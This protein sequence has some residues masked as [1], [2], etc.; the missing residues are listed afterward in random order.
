M[1]GRMQR[2]EFGS[3]RLNERDRLYQG[4]IQPAVPVNHVLL[5]R[6]GAEV[7]R[8]AAGLEGSYPDFGDD[9][10][11]DARVTV[12]ES[13]V[14]A[15]RTAAFSELEWRPGDRLELTAGVR[16]DRSSLTED[17]TWD[18]RLGAVFRLMDDVFL[19]GSWGIYHQV[20]APLAYEPEVGDPS[21]PSMRSLNSV[22]GI[23]VEGD[24]GL[25]RI[26][27]YHKRQQQLAQE[28]RNYRVVGGGRGFARG[29]DV[30]VRR[31]GPFGLQGHATYSFLDADR[32]DP[33]SGRMATSPFEIRH[34]FSLMLERAFGARF[35]LASTYRHASGRP[36]TAVVD[37]A[38]DERERVWRPVYG[39]P[40]TE[41]L[42]AYS[43]FDLTGQF[44]HSFGGDDLSVFF[45]S[46]TNLF[47]IA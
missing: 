1:S 9:N 12:F 39:P 22:V 13:E 7:E 35:G 41:R 5:A 20:P 42:P 32:T 33:N 30:F 28:D 14:L 46:V 18:P 31:R 16:G 47:L 38:F 8:R 43:R 25:L 17:A 6:G 29:L 3:F 44:L 10:R 21:L 34:A 45:V 27:A 15:T 37:A 11:P 2:Q 36:Y 23:V 19:T 40:M 26:E 24:R 4:R